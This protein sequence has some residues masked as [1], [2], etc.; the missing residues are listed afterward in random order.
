MC[1][2]HLSIVVSSQLSTLRTNAVGS[3]G[4]QFW[5]H[6]IHIREL[7]SIFFHFFQFYLIF[8]KEGGHYGF[9]ASISDQDNEKL[10]VGNP[11]QRTHVWDKVRVRKKNLLETF[12]YQYKHY[13]FHTLIWPIIGREK[14]THLP[15]AVSE[16]SI[17][18]MCSKLQ[19]PFILLCSFVT[20]VFLEGP[21]H[22]EGPLKGKETGWWDFIWFL[23]ASL[24]KLK[25]A[26]AC[27]RDGGARRHVFHGAL[28]PKDVQMASCRGYLNGRSQGDPK[29][30]L[31]EVGAQRAPRLLVFS[32]FVLQLHCLFVASG[33]CVVWFVLNCIDDVAV[34]L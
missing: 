28:K 30:L 23:V 10:V 11:M 22:H 4:R 25:M 31:L 5:I 12:R 7:S 24:S 14:A 27:W 8:R 18:E 34:T 9:T 3:G 19:V 1:Y 29:G 15:A 26:S 17:L 20:I 6:S 16:K 33:V 21:W 2:F 32:L 13:L